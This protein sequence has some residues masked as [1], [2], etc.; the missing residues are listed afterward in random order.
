MTMT[1]ETSE[2][3]SPSA[4]DRTGWP[5]YVIHGLA[6]ELAADHKV[7]ERAELRRLGDGINRPAF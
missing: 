3:Q 2:E 1:Q 7:G 5:V 4:T 6:T